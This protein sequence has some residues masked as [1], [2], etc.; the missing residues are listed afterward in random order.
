MCSFLSL[1]LHYCHKIFI[2]LLSS[3]SPLHWPSLHAEHL[4]HHFHYHPSHTDPSLSFHI[5]HIYHFIPNLIPSSAVNVVMTSCR[6]VY[7]PSSSIWSWASSVNCETLGL[8]GCNREILDLGVSLFPGSGSNRDSS[9]TLVRGTDLGLALVLNLGH[10]GMHN[11]YYGNTVRW[12]L[13]R[14][15]SVGCWLGAHG[16]DRYNR[17]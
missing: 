16:T 15:V 11:W 5:I 10:V 9:N 3:L 2:I 8:G 17:S 14:W 1:N 6:Q 7:I 13:K 12:L 4:S